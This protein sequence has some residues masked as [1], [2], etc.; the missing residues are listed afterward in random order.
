MG[1]WRS[2]CA[3]EN[4]C[5]RLKAGVAYIRLVRPGAAVETQPSVR[6]KASSGPQ[7]LRAMRVVPRKGLPFVLLTAG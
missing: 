5:H 4:P 3:A 6:V 1:K 2:L 7:R